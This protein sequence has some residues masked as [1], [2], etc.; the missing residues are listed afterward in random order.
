VKNYARVIQETLQAETGERPSYTWCR[1][2]VEKNLEA[3]K[4]KARALGVRPIDVLLD[5]AR[6][7]NRLAEEPLA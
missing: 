3:A 5:V 1:V 2:I 6:M 4:G 7:A